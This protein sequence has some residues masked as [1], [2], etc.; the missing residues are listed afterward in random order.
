MYARSISIAGRPEAVDDCI[1]FTRNEVLPVAA[2]TDGCLGVSLVVNHQSGRCI[3]T[4][5]WMTAESMALADD[6]L[7]P[8]RARAGEIL[9]G[10]P[11]VDRWEIS[12]MRRVRPSGE[13]AWC[14]IIWGRPAEIYIRVIRERLLNPVLRE[15][16]PT[17]GFCSTSLFV[18]RLERILC[19]TST[20]ESRAALDATRAEAAWARERMVR[21]T[22][23]EILEIAELELAV[24][25]LRVPELV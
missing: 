20:Y 14:R 24:A 10:D 7:A 5:A 2:R 23:V 22:G 6:E 11:V 19:S 4:S 21:E 18:D 17:E 25:H 9:R 16:E 3:G 13:G 1:D 15:L 8:L 12:V